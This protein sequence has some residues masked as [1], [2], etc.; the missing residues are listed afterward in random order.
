MAVMQHDRQEV[1]AYL[2]QQQASPEEQ[3][4]A[5]NWV[6]QGENLFDNP[7][8]LYD[9]SGQPMD[10]ISAMRTIYELRNENL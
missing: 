10:F 5:W 9:G 2:K 6:R 3:R 1:L 8:F 7:W 4:Q